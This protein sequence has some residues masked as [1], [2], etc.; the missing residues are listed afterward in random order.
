MHETGK[1]VLSLMFRPGETVCVSPNQFGYHSI[2]LENAMT[3]PV[4]LVP[5]EDS[6]AKRKM[7]LDQAIERIKSEEILLCA[8]NPIRG[9]RNDFNC[10]AFR[11]FLIEI[12]TGS[13]EQ[14]LAYIKKIGLPYSA[15]VFSGNKSLHFLI[16]LENDLPSERVYRVFSEWI[17]NIVTLADQMT[18][19]PSRSIRIPGAFREPGKQQLLVEFNG[20]VSLETLTSWLKSHP[21]AKPQEK[22]DRAISD[23]PDDFAKV[24][25]WICKKLINGI[26][27][28]QRNRQW[29]QVGVEFALCGYEEDDTVRRLKKYFSPD[30]DFKEREWET[31]IRSAFKWSYERKQ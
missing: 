14:Q 25:P 21:D 27:A 10:T 19:N 20:P 29:F 2:P 17:L 1:K 4:V 3:S 5:T 8:L 7:T 11:N 22:E 23:T 26:L 28:P 18:K 16:S 24:S 15:A 12:D 13:S 6:V 31:T 9:Y 30:R